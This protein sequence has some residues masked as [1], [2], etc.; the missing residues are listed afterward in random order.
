MTKGKLEKD[1]VD[2]YLPSKIVPPDYIRDILHE[3]EKDFPSVDF[4][5]E[6]P[7]KW[8]AEEYQTRYEEL[9]RLMLEILKWRQLWFGK[10]NV[11]K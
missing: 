8:R 10:M 3:A 11:T 1:L 2:P 4:E 7:H 5:Y 9:E 6:I